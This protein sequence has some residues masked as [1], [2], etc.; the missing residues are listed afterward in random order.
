MLIPSRLRIPSAKRAA[1]VW[2]AAIGTL[3]GLVGLGGA[4]FRLPVLVGRFGW[5]TL[6]A[7]VVNKIMSLIVVL[8]ALAMRALAVPLELL[9]TH[10]SVVL[11][12]L[13]GSLVGAWWAAGWVMRLPRRVLDAVVGGLLVLLALWML[14]HAWHPEWSGAALHGMTP[15]ARVGLGVVAGMAIGAVAAVLGVAGGEL[16]IPTLVLLWGLDVKLAGSLSL[17]ISLP[18]MLAGLLRYRRGPAWQAAMAARGW[19]L[20]MAAGSV[21]GVALGVAALGWIPARPLLALL[22]L[23]LLISAIKVFGHARRAVGG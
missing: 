11:N 6:S 5:A 17:C 8:A 13:A 3:G 7:I 19:L 4:E 20:V 22:A 15:L 14:G 23:L 9:W 10:A 18:T 21:C 12:V 2:G 16:L 1:F